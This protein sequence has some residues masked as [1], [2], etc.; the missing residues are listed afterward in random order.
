LAATAIAAAALAVVGALV[1]TGAFGGLDQYAVDHWMHH[2]RPGGRSSSSFASELYPKLGSPLLAFSSVW[3]YPAAPIVS[4]LVVLGCCLVLFRRG[5]RR[6]AVAWAAVWMLANAVEL[7][8]KSVLERPTL[9]LG[10]VPLHRFD[11]SFPSGHALRACLAAALLLTVWRRTA[12]P[13]RL[14]IVVALPALVVNSAHTPSDVLGGILVA[15]L[16][17]LAVRASLQLEPRLSSPRL[18]TAVAEQR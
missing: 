9:H 2:L 11:T 16:A 8:G 4:S 3:T 18:R 17:V 15:A 1:V 14:W 6:A 12:W 13:A 5:R 7:V 10:R